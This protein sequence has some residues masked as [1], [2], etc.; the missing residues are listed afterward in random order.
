MAIELD[1]PRLAPASGGAAKH[2]VVLLHGYGADGHELIQLGEIWRAQLPDAAFAAPNAPEPMALSA[3]GGY[4]WFDLT[5]RDPGELWRGAQ[6]AGP[7][8]DAFVDAELERLGL[9][10]D[11]IALVGF[12]QGSMMALHVG[13]RRKPAPAAIVGYSGGLA[14]PEHLAGDIAARPPVLLVHGGL[15]EVVPV[16]ALNLSKAALEAVGVPVEAH[17]RERLGHA[18][19]DEGLGL[20]CR[21]LRRALGVQAG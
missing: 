1:G 6:K 3:F 14:G 4:Q 9:K 12:S 15:D 16:D 5:F 21:F 7:A 17:V 20:G 18:I 2:L 10:G 11:R 13:L 19:D 8:L